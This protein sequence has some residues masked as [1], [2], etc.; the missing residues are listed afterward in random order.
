MVIDYFD[1][2]WPWRAFRPLEANPPLVIDTYVVLPL[3]V[4]PER[5]QTIARQGQ[6]YKRR[7][8]LQ[9]VEFHFSSVLAPEEGFYPVSFGEL[10]SSFV[11]EAHNHYHKI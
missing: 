1:I 2:Y 11:S 4:A 3:A 9:L 8:G 5:F 7:G 6:V 10:T